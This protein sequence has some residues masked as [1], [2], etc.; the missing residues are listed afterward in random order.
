[1][2]IF[3]VVNKCDL[4][5]KLDA[6]RLRDALQ[7]TEVVR[8]SAT[9]PG[10]TGVLEETLASLVLRGEAIPGSGEATVTSVRHLDALRRAEDHVKAA[11]ASSGDGVPAAF[12]AVDLHAAL[13]DLG[14][15]PPAELAPLARASANETATRR[16]SAQV[17]A[18]RPEGEYAIQSLASTIERLRDFYDHVL[19]MATVSLACL[20]AAVGLWTG[21]RAGYRLATA[22]LLTNLLGDLA[23]AVVR[24]DPRTL[25]GI[26][27]V[28][29]LLWYL[30]LREPL[31][32]HGAA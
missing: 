2:P 6:D 5:L 22:L 12:V 23:N 10:G 8:A 16:A 32:P 21:R 17:L 30:R 1:M 19:L 29:V 26:P 3:T 20:G 24:R 27:I 13:N 18:V 31:Q 14:E 11:L 4:P 9:E 25:I 15:E 28:A 7:G